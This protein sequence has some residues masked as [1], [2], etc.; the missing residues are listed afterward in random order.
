M[1]SASW[2][3]LPLVCVHQYEYRSVQ[4]TKSNGLGSSD[5]GQMSATTNGAPSAA[6]NGYVL[7]ILYLLVAAKLRNA[8]EYRVLPNTATR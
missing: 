5:V 2:S 1:A 3:E 7:H 6:T 8:D 4:H